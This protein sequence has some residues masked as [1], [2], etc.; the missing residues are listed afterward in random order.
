M[1]RRVAVVLVTV[2]ALVLV[3]CSPDAA[4][5]RAELGSTSDAE[6]GAEATS[7]AVGAVD[8]EPGIIIA[9]TPIPEGPRPLIVAT[10]LGETNVLEAL[11][12]PALAGVIAEIDRLN[13][14]GGLLGRPVVLRRF[15]TDSRASLA[16][17][18]MRRLVDQPPDLLIVSCDTEVSKP[19][20][21]IADENGILTISPCAD[22]ARYLTGGLGSR[23]FTLGAPAEGQGA[24]AAKAGLE[25][26]GPTALVLRDVTSPEALAFCDGFERAFRELGGSVVY[27]DEF[28]YDTLAP[29]L[30]RLSERGRDSDFITLCSHAPGARA[31]EPRNDAGP[32]LILNLRTL[33]FQAPIVAGSTLDE[34]AWFPMV[35]TLGEMIFVSWS[36][37]Y[38][39]DPDERIND[40]IERVNDIDDTPDPGVTT[41]LGA[42][43]IQAW[44]RAVE[45]ARDTSPDRVAAA[46]GSFNNEDFATGQI[47]FV[48]GARMDI[49]RN[50]RILQ[51]LDGELSVVALEE[52]QN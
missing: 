13:D 24:V 49:G 19:V 16:E 10:L 50:Y 30:D 20:L 44:A 4:T 40:V 46:L 22:D 7:I 38:G 12:G 8:V 47:S 26:F 9:P 42:E 14:D 11:D 3:S 27:R 33:G 15:N 39:N 2:L 34:A 28:S 32:S 37:A 36:S 1:V 51:V 17:R 31:A 6:A 48:A 45:N 5:S 41:I 23:N 29:V 25:R 52:T 18:Q 35:P 43:A 21:D